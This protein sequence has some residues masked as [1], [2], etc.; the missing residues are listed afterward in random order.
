V[1]TLRFQRWSWQRLSKRIS[2]LIGCGN[3]SEGD[4]TF[5]NLFTKPMN[6]VIPMFNSICFTSCVGLLLEDKHGM[7]ACKPN[8]VKWDHLF[9]QVATGPTHAP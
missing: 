9:Q 4:G 2:H 5:L 8:H 6:L 1:I 7:R 3:P